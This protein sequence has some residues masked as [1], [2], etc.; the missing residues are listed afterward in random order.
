MKIMKKT[1]LLIIVLSSVVWSSQAQKATISE[2]NNRHYE[3]GVQ[4]GSVGIGRDLTLFGFGINATIWGVYIDFLL[5][6]AEHHSSKKVGHWN[7]NQ[8]V[9]LH[10][11]YQLPITKH[12]RIIPMIGYGEVNEGVTDGYNYN[13]DENGVH[14][15]YKA[16]WRDKGVDVGAS[17]VFHFGML[18]IYATGSLWSVYGGLGIEF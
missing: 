9:V 11:G 12:F 15:S 6:G 18:N 1:L 5:N 13:I 7:D 2:V 3:I 10:I 17:A 14:N 8:G 16:T 4:L